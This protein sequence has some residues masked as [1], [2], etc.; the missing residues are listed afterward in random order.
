MSTI[1]AYR[2]GLEALLATAVDAA[3]WP[4]GLKDEALAR[5]LWDFDAALIY[6]SN[7]TITIDGYVQ[8][9]IGL[10][11]LDEVLAVAWPWREG[12]DF[13][14]LTV[15]WRI[16]G[17]QM[18]YLQSARKPQAGEVMRLRHT[19]RHT[20]DGLA[21]AETTTVPPRHQHLVILGAGLWA[22]DLRLRQI[23]E[24][25]A[26]PQNANAALH[27]LRR[28]LQAR[29]EERLGRLLNRSPIRWTIDVG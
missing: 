22:L 18:I 24:N 5:G 9:L 27:A 28:E 1:A 17:D 11:N 12:E 15:R 2:T 4:N 13:A 21:G 26:L 6:E 10:T 19:L 16:V 7:V 23:S 25:P 8:D 14:R 29:Y 20:I 3:T